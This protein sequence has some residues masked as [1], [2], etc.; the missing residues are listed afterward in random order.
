[1]Q[2]KEVMDHQQHQ[3]TSETLGQLKGGERM[4]FLYE[5]EIYLLVHE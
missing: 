5:Q 4:R 3:P 1:M 2:A